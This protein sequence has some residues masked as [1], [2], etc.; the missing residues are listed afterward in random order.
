[1][2]DPASV[3]EGAA[4]VDVYVINLKRSADRWQRWA[5]R[6]GVCRIE[7]VDGRDLDLSAMTDTVAPETRVRI[8]AGEM[9]KY[10][11]HAHR[12]SQIGCFMSHRRAWESVRDGHAPF[13]IVFEDDA[14]VSDADIA[15]IRAAVRQKL[16]EQPDLD[17]VIVSPHGVRRDKRGRVKAFS[18]MYSYAVTRAGAERGLTATQIMD[19]QVDRVL[20][21]LA[22]TDELRLETLKKPVVKQS[23]A[24]LLGHAPTEEERIYI[25]LGVFILIALVGFIVTLVFLLRC[26]NRALCALCVSPQ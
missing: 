21:N 14:L 15:A 19:G 22:R 5:G 12:L 23:G 20:G 7:A 4:A 16:A 3:E 26:R 9:Q 8:L 24:S 18:G 25:V 17:F 6:P 1:M 10:K 13:G 2:A 11:Y